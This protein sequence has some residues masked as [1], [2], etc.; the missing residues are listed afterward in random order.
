MLI[1]R[2]SGH[3]IARKFSEMDCL[4]LKLIVRIKVNSQFSKDIHVELTCSFY[5][6]M[7]FV[8]K[9]HIKIAQGLQF[10]YF[11]IVYVHT[12]TVSICYSKE[13]FFLF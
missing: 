4:Q 12:F 9:I 5:I 11:S 2:F 6:E 7:K 3:I 1:W 8:Y 10:I 13:D